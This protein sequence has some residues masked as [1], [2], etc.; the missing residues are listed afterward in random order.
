[1]A[2]ARDVARY[3]LASGARD[4]P[5]LQKLLYYAQ[6]WSLAWR[7]A[8]L[9]REPIRAWDYGPVVGEIWRGYRD[10]DL[11]GDAAALTAEEKRVVDAVLEY[12]GQ[13]DGLKLSD[14][15]HREEPWQR[16]YVAGARPS[17][18]IT[19]DAL[20]AFYGAAATAGSWRVPDAYR[21]GV[22]LILSLSPDELAD[23]R[24]PT[25]PASADEV[26]ALLRDA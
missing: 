11:G 24:S 14:L 7:D 19:H 22:E 8:P 4:A 25:A 10:G 18:T 16:A 21:R 12:Y 6:A 2:N 15:T 13:F 1:M 17:P 20:R 3:I 26:A 23:L 5:A 9:F